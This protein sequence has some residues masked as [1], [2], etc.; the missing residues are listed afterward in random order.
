MK[1][2]IAKPKLQQSQD[3]HEL[4]MLKGLSYLGFILYF[5]LQQKEKLWLNLLK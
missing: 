5:I 3:F 4:F 1:E 2:M